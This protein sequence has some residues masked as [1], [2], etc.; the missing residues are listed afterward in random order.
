M[1]EPT[2]DD[3]P[4]PELED[5]TPPPTDDDHAGDEPAEDELEDLE[6]G[7]EGQDDG[8]P[9]T[10][11]RREA[12]RHRRRLREVEAER[13]ALAETVATYRRREA[14]AVAGTTLQSGGDL[15]AAGVDLAELL[16]EDGTVDEA[17]V[18]AAVA[19]VT[20]ERP[21]WRRKTPDLDAGARS[22]ARGSGFDFGAE[23]R[24]AAG[25]NG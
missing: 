15:W 22:P 20:E 10:A 3:T 9:A 6:D 18:R 13:D 11:A 16:G 17:R 8:D 25:A 2:T 21:H 14:E 4:E 12:A 23:L 24:R 19:K 1:P 7:D 5:T